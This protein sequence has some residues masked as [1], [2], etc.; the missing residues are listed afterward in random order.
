M[1]STH[2]LLTTSTAVLAVALLVS[3]PAAGQ[4]IGSER[5]A[6]GLNVPLFLDAP[7]G[8]TT[9]LFVLEQNTARIRIIENDTLLGTP[10]L[11]IGS[12][13]SSGG[14]R[15][16][17]GMAFHPDY[18]VNGYFYVNY[19]DNSGRTKVARYTVSA[20]P[21]VADASSALEILDVYQPQSNHNGGMIAFG[22]NDGYLYVGMG[23]GGGAGDTG[24]NAQDLSLLRGKMLRLDVD[25]GSPYAIPGDNPF[26]NDPNARD[27]IWAY[28]LRNPW[29]YSFDR[30]NG[31]MW[32]ADVGQDIWEE[33]DWQPA[34]SA[35]GENY[36]WRLKEGDHCFNP[37]SNCDPGGLTDPVHE[38]SHGGQP[39]RCSITGGYVYRGS[40][41]PG[42]QGTYFFAD[43]CS[44]QIWSLRFENGAVV[45]LVDRTAELAPGGGMAINDITSFGQDAS[46]ELYVI[47]GGG[48]VFKIVPRLM[49][50]SVSGLVAGQS[51]TLAASAATAGARV[52]FTYSLTGAGQTRV[53]ALSVFL[54]LA[55]PRLA[56]SATANAGGVA[57]LTRSVPAGALG[58]TVTMQ[59]A[60][61]GN[62]SD[63]EVA[64]V[65]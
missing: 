64:T 36:G 9:R 17:L 60:E 61:N 15:G 53:D 50:L 47:D 16:L 54:G 37:S 41:I 24:N 48:E 52:F 2:S 25:G 42:L 55:A 10:F 58:L 40:A 49:D 57:S 30:E 32:I 1:R 18:A 38:Y 8:D 14:E 12:L 7:P 23:D 22:P 4:K 39:F 44:Q 26:V 20:N 19:T 43:Y 51:T 11:D 45:D 34:N 5:V 28:G 62:T 31:E 3:A 13:A 27:E 21:N 65:Q 6:S 33:I 56:G 46:G 63:L 35:G 59:A 29:R